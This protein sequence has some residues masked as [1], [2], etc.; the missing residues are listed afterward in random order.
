MIAA[1]NPS[2]KDEV[3]VLWR[4]ATE[5]NLIFNAIFRKVKLKSKKETL[6]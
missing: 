4:E 6:E 5:I 3:I 1:A 2:M